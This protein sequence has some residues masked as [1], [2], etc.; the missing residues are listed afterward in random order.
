MRIPKPVVLC[1]LDGWG[2]SDTTEA[3]A[4]ALA[5]TPTYDHIMATCPTATL[6]THGP[7][8]G[9]PKGQMGNSEVGHTNIGA[10]RVVAMDL[11][12]IDLAIEDGSFAEN[13]SLNDMI[14]TLKGTGGTA[15]VMGLVS[16]GGVHGSLPHIIAAV[17]AITGAG[18]PV[19]LHAITD[20][21]DVAP[22]SALGF[23]EEL[24]AALP[25]TARIATLSG[26][27]YAMD[28]DNRWDRVHLAYDAMV[29]ARGETAATPEQAI[30][31]SYA[32]GKVDEFILPTV[33]G[34]FGGA[35]DGDGFFCLNF[36]ADRARE[37]LAAIGKP[38]FDGF[39]TGPRPKWAALLGMVEYSTDHSTYMTTCYPKQ[40]IVNT[41][42]QWVAAHHKTQF[43]LAETEKYPHV[44][45]FLDGGVEVQKDG[46]DRFMPLSPKVATYDM[47]PEMSSVEVTD[48]FVT[49]IEQGYDLIITNYANPDMVGHTGDLQAAMAA[50]AAVDKGLARVVAALQKAGGAMLLTADHGNCEVMV[51]PVTGGP[52]TAHTTNLVPVALIGGPEGA[53]LRSGRLADIAP[54]LLQLMGL[55]K[56]AEMTGESLIE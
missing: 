52:H 7:D 15:H 54:T 56:P 45:F 46:E 28:R 5:D 47:Q 38:D 20:G 34:D 24:G 10:G 37:I 12:Q 22:R 39:D 8:V 17:Q 55:E 43:R 21:R 44:T 30:E 31:Q 33:I 53:A 27:Y 19:A 48:H 49:A 11:G 26:R 1:I 2:L 40:K 3:N 23:L 32:A 35:R 50:C 16:D 41:L 36:R 6:I 42:G 13:A 9:L 29:N 4:P 51:D 18:V 14:A 25:D